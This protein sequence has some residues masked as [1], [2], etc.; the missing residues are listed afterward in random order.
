MQPAEGPEHVVGPRALDTLDESD[1]MTD[2]ISFMDNLDQEGWSQCNAT[3]VV[4]I[5]I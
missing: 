5:I 1:D 4:L 3:A 2:G